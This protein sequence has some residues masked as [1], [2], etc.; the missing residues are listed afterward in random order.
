MSS[1]NVRE[2]ALSPFPSLFPSNCSVGSH[3][4][5]SS[6]SSQVVQTP[7][8][9]RTYIAGSGTPSLSSSGSRALQTPSPTIVSS[10][11]PNSPSGPTSV[12][13]SIGMTSALLGSPTP[14]CAFLHRT[15][16]VSNQSSPSSSLSALSPIPSPSRS[17][18]S[19]GFIGN[20]SSISNTPSLS[21]SWSVMSQSRS[22]S[23]SAGT[24]LAS[25]ESVPQ[26]GSSSSSHPSLS[27]SL[28]A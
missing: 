4:K 23:L 27:S 15:S 12:S 26:L 5:W 22:M 28:S 24:E 17:R 7:L 3:G 13:L 8:A 10:S 11:V 6:Q 21:S 1:I 9:S 14:P 16:V 2:F 20:A 25:I 19:A 18:Y